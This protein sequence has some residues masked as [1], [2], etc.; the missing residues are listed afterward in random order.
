MT[1]HGIRAAS[2]ARILVEL[3]LAALAIWLVVQNVML[4][5]V[6]SWASPPAALVLAS[7]LFKTAKILIAALWPW[8]LMIAAV[9]AMLGAAIAAAL[10]GGAAARAKEAHRA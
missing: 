1:T 6:G 3:T 2:I 5:S 7:V 9:S 8:P 10:L 4:L